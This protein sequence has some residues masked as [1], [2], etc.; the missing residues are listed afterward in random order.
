[1]SEHPKTLEDTALWKIYLE[2]GPRQD[3]NRRIWVKDIYENA[4]TY[5]KEVRKTFP[6]YTLH[7]ETHVLNVIYTM[8]AVLGNQ[9]ECL[10]VGEVEL[11]ILAAS[12][13]DIGMVYDEADRKKAFNDERKCSR[14]LKEN[15]PELLGVP[16][17]GWTEETKQWYLRKLHPFRLSEILCTKEWKNL[18][19]KCP[20]EI[21]PEQNIVAVCQSHGEE[22]FRIKNNDLLK[23]LSAYETD[24]LF[25]ALLLRLADLL[26][27]DDTRAPQ[28]LFKY[29]AGNDE[30]V[31]EWRKHMDSLGFKYSQNPSSD[32][33]I[34]SAKCYEPSEEYS[35]R[36]FLNWIDDELINCKELQRLCDKKWQREFQFPRSVSRDGITRIGYVSDEFKIT[37][38]QNQ[39][40]KLLIGENLYESNDIFIR[41]L[42]QNAVDAVL[43]RG[44]MEPGYKVEEARI[45]LWEWTDKD[46][47]ILF[48]IDDQGTGMTIGILK[49]Y[50][51][52]VGNSYY[53]SKELKRDLHD[54]GGDREFFG[55]SRFGIGFLSCFLCGTEAEVSTLYF[56]DNKSKDDYSMGAGD[57]NGYGLRMQITGLSG[58][59]TLRSQADGH[60]IN[61][62][63]PA[64]EFIN[65]V[66]HPSLE[67]NGYRSKAGTSIVIKLDPGKLG[68][69]NLKDA[70]EKYI[71]GTRVPIFYNGER[72]GCTYSEIMKKAHE[73]GG[74]TSYELSDK[75]KEIFD[76]TFPHVRG[77]YPKIVITV[78][79]LDTEEYQSIS[80]LTGILV[81]YD[82]QFDD[83][84]QW[85]VMDQT[86][87]VSGH[88][89]GNSEKG[90]IIS[91][92]VINV[93]E[94]SKS[95]YNFWDRL[96]NIYGE[97]N[98]DAL[99]ETLEKFTACPISAEVLGDVWL[100]FAEDRYIP[101]V[102]RS[103]V[104]DN[105]FREMEIE[106]N[107][108]VTAT[109]E[110]LTLNRQCHKVVCVYQGIFVSQF[111]C[112]QH[113][114]SFDL[115]F[116]LENEL[117]PAVD[118]GRTKVLDLPLQA[119]AAISVIL[120]HPNVDG[121]ETMRELLD[122]SNNIVLPEWRR[123]RDTEL[124]RWVLKTQNKRILHIQELSQTPIR[125]DNLSGMQE[126]E[127][128]IRF[129][130][131]GYVC[132]NIIY[133]FAMAYFQDVYDMEICYENGQTLIFSKKENTE[134]HDCFDKFPPMMFC[135]AGSDES[136]RYLCCGNR[137][138]RRGI[139]L[140]HPFAEWFI[141]NA[142]K[143]DSHFPRQFQQ[144]VYDLC[145]S[146]SQEI[147]DTVSEFR[148]QLIRLNG[149]HDINVFSLPVLTTDDFWY[150]KF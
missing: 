6:N 48:R 76:R 41:E 103:Y 125:V 105:Q 58:Y 136:R 50:F 137:I 127:H 66:E 10:S 39:I 149:S 40:L 86:Y 23:Y 113:Y 16:Y 35:I 100:P 82:I 116:F 56:D 45:D 72:I 81:K 92:Q 64:P 135:K 51:L 2:K 77:Q 131:S 94:Y 29:A 115:V 93:R 142:I 38:D 17:T 122:S 96:P 18:F 108:R 143:L 14:F 111:R 102:W 97:E 7:D 27:F 104:D 132:I 121:L 138:C 32:E 8:G 144:I 123:L 13:H 22:S 80:S 68:T 90:I 141:E 78:V 87:K 21:V 114:K 101:E 83:S 124:G 65:S 36:E 75:E 52:K 30:S 71:C 37:M 110:S 147:I 24:P 128:S 62:E 74:E 20:H 98:V 109:L 57:N 42:L 31:K 19:N 130:P 117:Q 26:D 12:L 79:P 112:D 4:I 107:N 88:I 53:T 140:D 91:L 5:L 61:T 69:I 59:Y 25:C 33:L 49:R 11:L 89:S 150:P 133:K 67:Y 118:I 3:S 120:C 84:V 47:N 148:Q 134:Y 73:L 145:N 129:I 60:N 28:I 34:F 99:V 44:K 95:Y 63:L 43:L 119:L 85:Q 15:S 70:A 1:M 55:I 54:H 106:L 9:I 46:G 139:T 146:D 126:D